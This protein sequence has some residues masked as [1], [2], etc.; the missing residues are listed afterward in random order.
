M[1]RP[2]PIPDDPRDP[3]RPNP[4]FDKEPTRTRINKA[5]RRVVLDDTEFIERYR[6]TRKRSNIPSASDAVQVKHDLLQQINIDDRAWVFHDFNQ[7][8]NAH[9]YT[10]EQRNGDVWYLEYSPN[11]TVSRDETDKALNTIFDSIF[12]KPDAW[13]N[14]RKEAR[15]V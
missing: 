10:Y 9:V 11:E 1:S 3:P 6:E 15:Q 5:G 8:N 7:L 2:E 13:I 12:D 4:V 14:I